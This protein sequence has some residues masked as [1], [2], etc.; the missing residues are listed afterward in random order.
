[1]LELFLHSKRLECRLLLAH[2]HGSLAQLNLRART[3]ERR[4]IEVAWI[5]TP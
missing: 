2:Y 1:M 3:C 4:G 5:F